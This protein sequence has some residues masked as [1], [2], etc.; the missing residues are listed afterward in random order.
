MRSDASRWALRQQP[1]GTQL[2]DPDLYDFPYYRALW[3]MGLDVDVVP[4][5]ADLTGYRVVVAATQALMDQ[6]LADRLARY[7]A[8]GG[9]LVLSVRTGLKDDAGHVW[10]DGAPGPLADLCGVR[11]AEFDAPPADDG[12]AIGFEDGAW[13]EAGPWRERLERLEPVE[14][15]WIVAKYLQGYLAD[16]P[17]IVSRL[18][19][20]GRVWYCGT[21]GRGPELAEH[22]LRSVV[23]HASLVPAVIPGNV[24][25]RTRPG[26]RG[27]LRFVLNHSAEFKAI[28]LEEDAVELLTGAACSGILELP[29]YGAAVLATA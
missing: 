17:A 15:T 4:P 9:L 3:T 8:G 13:F 24:E 28:G 10:P 25:I 2:A 1:L 6:D 21:L 7:A 19:G 11:V 20:E 23:A 18:H 14:G 29:P 26:P 22:L 16:E 27:P 12:Q 5:D